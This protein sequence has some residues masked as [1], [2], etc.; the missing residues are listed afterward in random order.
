MSLVSLDIVQLRNLHQVS[1][2]P[3]SQFNLI[4]GA[5]G[6]GKS[7]LL[8]AIFLLGLGRSFRTQRSRRL[9]QEGY[10]SATVFA[11]LSSGSRIGVLKRASGN[12]EARING[13][14]AASLSALA[15]QLPLQ[16]FDPESLLLVSGPSLARRQLLDW[17]VFHVEP[18]FIS[19][20][21]RARRALAQRNSLLKSAKISIAELKVWEAELVSASLELSEQRR[22]LISRWLP[23]V[24]ETLLQYLPASHMSISFFPGWDDDVD[25]SELLAG[26]RAKD[27]ERGFTAY[28]PHR[29]DLK[30]KSH[31]AAA[32]E[33][34]SRGQL[35]LCACLIKL[36]LSRLL[37]KECGIRPVLLFDDLSS[38]LDESARSQVVEIV[39]TLSV[40]S[41]FTCIDRGQLEK[42]LP[43]QGIKMFH[44]EQGCVVPV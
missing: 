32:D 28:G 26:S 43:A 16:L 25:Y 1:L 6:S 38:E 5:N 15:Q 11:E 39:E 37:Q 34:L 35:K 31:G 7:S 13:Q 10:D 40:Q 29:A 33:R 23:D 12:T 4:Y 36:A 44:V 18:T 19:V 8:E 9:V 3:S 24:E 17:G 21:S 41:F 2:Q 14:N 27:R 20:W 42:T 30:I 22:R